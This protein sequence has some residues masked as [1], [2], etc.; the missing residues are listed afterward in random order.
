MNIVIIFHNIGGYHAARLRAAQS[1]LNDAGHTLTAIQETD[2]AHEHPWG[3]SRQTITFPLI[4]LLP[5]QEAAGISQIDPQSQNAAKRL[6]QQLEKLK[7][8]LL[9]IPGWGFPIARTALTW[10]KRQHIPTILMSDS[11]WD[12]E[13]RQWWK[14]T[15]KSL[16]YVNKFNAALVA[17]KL[18]KD[19]LVRL[20][21]AKESIFL[22]YD[23][24]DNQ[25]FTEKSQQIQKNAQITRK[26][27]PN[28][29][30]A[31]YFIAV[32]RFI[33]RKN[34]LLLLRAYK[35][36]RQQ[37]QAIPWELVLCGSGADEA[38]IKQFIRAENLNDVVHLP[39]FVPYQDIPAWYALA[40]AFIHPALQEQW[41]LVVNEAMAAGLP[42]LVSNRCGCFPE[43]V[44]E[45]VNGFGFDPDDQQQLTKLMLKI[46]SGEVELAVMGQAS[47]QHIQK[48]SPDYFAQ[49]LADAIQY[50]F[51]NK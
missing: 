19:Y 32:T 34:L 36:Y 26:K 7:P 3:N 21:M 15:I 30:S 9:A 20:G 35:G 12:D 28:I 25:Y 44:L 42:V 33:P 41:G 46:S 24:V 22:G 37:T 31:P 38:T 6:P 47:L 10:A 45:G 17:G 13:P 39:G 51:Q 48:Y 49:G 2:N 8:D 11:K 27:Y 5:S 43:L 1:T 40:G 4:T 50:T 18:H 29:P 23:V 16:L 14:E